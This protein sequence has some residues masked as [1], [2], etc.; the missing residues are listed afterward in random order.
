MFIY[1]LMCAIGVILGC[2]G[3]ITN[4][5]LYVAFGYGIAI[6]NRLEVMSY[7]IKTTRDK[8]ER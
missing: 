4:D 5:V 1:N 2:F 6:L 8:E 7:E 3:M